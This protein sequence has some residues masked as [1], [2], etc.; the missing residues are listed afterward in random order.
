MIYFIFNF[1]LIILT[2]NQ[3]FLCNKFLG[4]FNFIIFY[5][6]YFYFYYFKLNNLNSFL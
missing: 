4:L 6:K 1:K 3:Y 2:F 5:V